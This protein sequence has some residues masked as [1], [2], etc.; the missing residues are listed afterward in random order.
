[1]NGLILIIVEQSNVTDERT[2]RIKK[3][4]IEYFNK[5]LAELREKGIDDDTIE[6]IAEEIGIGKCTMYIVHGSN[7]LKRFL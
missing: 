1:M 4:L 3:K 7:Q 6:D 5:D 2:L